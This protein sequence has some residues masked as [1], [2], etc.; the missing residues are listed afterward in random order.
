MDRIL[1]VEDDSSIRKA[2]TMGLTSKN[3]EV[4]NAKDGFTGVYMG[5]QK[6]YDVLVTDLCLPD[7]NGIQVIEKI[8]KNLPDIVPIV[9][10]GRGSMESTIEAIRLEVADYLEK[11]VSLRTVEN[12][13]VQGLKKRSLKQEKIQSQL[14][15]IKDQYNKNDFAE[16]IPKV[17]H[18]INNPLAVINA[19]VLLA[20]RSLDDKEKLEQH[21][22][23]ILKSSQK[24]AVTNK[25]IMNLGNT[26]EGKT[27][28]HRAKT[29]FN[30]CLSIFKGLISLNDIEIKAN[31]DALESISVLDPYKIEQILSNLILNAVDAM[32]DCKLK[33][34]EITGSCD[35]KAGMWSVAIQ[36]SG[37]G[38]PDDDLSK[39]LLPY[40]TTKSH[41]TG[42]GLSVAGEMIKSLGGEIKIQSQPN[43]GSR[44][45]MT[46][47]L[48]NKK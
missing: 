44:F 3:Y 19:A 4:D 46:L 17:V 39:V 28:P 35:K 13:I 41:G 43:K 45:T 14:I 26:L 30:D 47:P 8:K 37:C 11:P 36:D 12:A 16:S 38:I 22:S 7:Y 20:R 33:R 29:F 31:F 25:S 42:L 10:T 21:L 32:D 9:I 27:K 40:F 34:L 5:T 1:I 6:K 24:I 48:N 18:Q 2:L 15:N 23:V